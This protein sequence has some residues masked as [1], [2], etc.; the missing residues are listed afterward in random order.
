MARVKSPLAKKAEA[1]QID[2]KSHKKR[3][4]KAWSDRS[5]WQKFYDD[6]YEFAIPYRRPA[7]REGKAVDKIERLFDAT[8]IESSFRAA[9]QL[10]A[11]LFPPDFFK[12]APGAISKLAM[13]PDDLTA[14]KKQLQSISEIVNAFFQTGEF[15]TSTSEMCIDLL[16]G[17]GSLFPVEGDSVSP[18]RFVCVPFDEL[19]IIV[20]AYG[21]VVGIFWRSRLSYRAIK[22]AF[23]D[24]EYP[25][26]FTDKLNSSPEDE[27]EIN[28]DFVFNSDTN[29]WD[30]VAYL[31]DSERPIKTDVYKTQPMAVPRYHRVPGEPYGRGPIL[32]ALPTIKTLNKAVELTLK[33]AAI[34]MLGI[35]GYRP[36]GAFNPDTARLAPGEFWP[37]Q[38][39]GGVLGPDVTRLDVGGGKVDLGNLVTSELRLQV[40]S[41]LGDDRLPDKGATPVSATEIMARMKRISQNYMGAWARIVNEVHPVIVRRVIEILARKQVKGVPDINID[42]LLI[43]LDVLSPITQAIKAAAHSRI[44]DFIQL[45]V[46]V[47]GTPMAADLIVKVDDALQAIAEDQIPANLVVSLKERKALQKQ[48]AAAAAQIAAAQNQ[49][50]QAA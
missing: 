16:V 45:C 29:K 48:M 20:D 34:Q 2:L 33:A 42:A 25:K 49:Q 10:H 9:G 27:I 46:A 41:M 39:T 30:F 24:G 35:Y 6:A 40:Q 18:V 14:L 15:D 37:M 11:D 21:K 28:Q 13:S 7:S 23:K 32:L 43:K 1:P 17:T 12:L 3:A 47:K 8:A 50:K 5:L 4:E 19:A 36:G 26:S 31:T 44:I 22:D 38:A